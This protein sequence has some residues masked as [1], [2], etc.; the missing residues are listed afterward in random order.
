[1]PSTTEHQKIAPLPD[2]HSLDNERLKVFW[3]LAE[4]GRKNPDGVLS[5]YAIAQRLERNHRVDVPR[6][7]VDAILRKERKTV[8]R[9]VRGGT[10]YW[11]LMRAGEIE[12]EAPA[13]VATFIDPQKAFT[14]RKRVYEILSELAGHLRFCDPY[15]DSSVLA[16]LA[17]CNK[18][19][20]IKLLTSKI[21]SLNFVPDLAAFNR[22]FQGKIQ[23]RAISNSKQKLHDRYILHSSGMILF[24]ASLK[25][26]GKAPSFVVA[27]GPDLTEAVSDHFD[28]AWNSATAVE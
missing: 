24:G 22:E 25:D 8:L 5:S 17:S 12:L 28:N 7:R 4:E 21:H 26:I 15:I 11:K 20:T 1:M 10:E 9:R 27:L 6:H 14:S 19:T 18:A 2:L 3:I 23:V 16:A 13:D